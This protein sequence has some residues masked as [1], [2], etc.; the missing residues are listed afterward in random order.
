M[1]HQ[2]VI[3]ATKATEK[4]VDQ[5]VNRLERFL[6][7][8]IDR[9]V[10]DVQSGDLD[11]LTV[12]AQL[13]NVQTGL[14]ELG[15]NEQYEEIADI[16]GDRLNRIKDIFESSSGKDFILTDSDIDVIDELIS[17]D[18]NVVDTNVTRA[19]DDLNSVVF[20]SVIAGTPID[21]DQAVGNATGTMARNIRTE[22]NTAL[23]SF[24][25]SVNVSKAKD[26]GLQWF[27]YAG[28]IIKTSRDFCIA[29]AGKAYP[30]SRLNEWNNDQ[31]IPVAISLGGYNCR[32][33][34][35]FVSEE[36]ARRIGIG[37][38]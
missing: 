12:A 33:D 24:S 37:S 27:V 19:V 36:E 15:L 29:R 6:N 31:G 3:R 21:I 38:E 13:S 20:R 23:A 8:N 5:F 22:L 10:R 17:F 30:A 1:P 35:I 18:A 28:T 4:Q 14:Q 25:R 7:S 32:H 16:Y 9:L 26:Q 2:K 11:A 34:A